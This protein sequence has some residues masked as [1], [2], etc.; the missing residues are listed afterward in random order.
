MVREHHFDF[1]LAHIDKSGLLMVYFLG[2]S[3][4][5][6]EIERL[7]HFPRSSRHRA[8]TIVGAHGALSLSPPRR[9]EY[10]LQRKTHATNEDG[11]SRS[12]FLLSIMEEIKNVTPS[13]ADRL[14]RALVAEL[15]RTATPPKEA[16][17]EGPPMRPESPR[18]VNLSDD[19][20]RRSIMAS[21]AKI[22]TERLALGIVMLTSDHQVIEGES[23]GR[24]QRVLFRDLRRHFAMAEGLATYGLETS[25]CAI[26]R[27]PADDR[28]PLIGN[29]F[30]PGPICRFDDGSA[31]RIFDAADIQRGMRGQYKKWTVDTC[32]PFVTGNF[33]TPATSSPSTKIPRLRSDIIAALVKGQ[34]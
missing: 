19:M 5:R 34:S 15:R 3:E 30:P 11:K 14:V 4:S 8:L 27:G 26:V 20:L 7:L 9:Y 12:L 18:D 10:S 25:T 6:T 21:A 24:P 22:Y 2:K 13:A 16:E 32:T 28:E 31:V 17:P 1:L 23:F 33:E 29:V